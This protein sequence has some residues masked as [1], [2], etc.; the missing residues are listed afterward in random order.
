[1]VGQV[2]AFLNLVRRTLPDL[3]ASFEAI[4]PSLF[5]ASETQM[6]RNLYST[7]RAISFSREVLQEQPGDLLVL[8]A[9]PGLGWS[10]LGEP[11]FS[12][13]LRA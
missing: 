10:D 12:L 9:P 6:V 2:N 11:V 3:V 5:T 1:M 13:C 4:R 7:I 8:C